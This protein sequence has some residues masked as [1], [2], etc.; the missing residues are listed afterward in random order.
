MSSNSREEKKEETKKFSVDED[1]KK[2]VEEERKRL[3]QQEQQSTEQAAPERFPEPD[4]K[5]FLAGLYT[6]TL[7]ALGGL[8]H[9]ESH[10]RAANLPEARY[11]IDTINMLKQKTQGNLT[12]DE[13]TYLSS[14]LHDLRMRYVNALKQSAVPP[15]Q[16]PK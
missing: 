15:G 14:L 5:V 3:D 16:Q 2:S 8:E 12:G 9:P 6:Q 4:F 1:W 13:D 7:V 10:E 11:L